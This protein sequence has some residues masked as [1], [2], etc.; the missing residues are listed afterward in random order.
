MVF[1]NQGSSIEAACLF[2][3][4]IMRD[5]LWPMCFGSF[6]ANVW[7]RTVFGLRTWRLFEDP[8]EHLCDA[9]KH[10]DSATFRQSVPPLLI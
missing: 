8:N 4:S 5:L 9:Q 3:P 6:I 1:G 10:A 7:L 2:A